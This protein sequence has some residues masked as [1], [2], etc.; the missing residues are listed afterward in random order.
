MQSQLAAR[1]AEARK[2]IRSKY[3]Q[4]E[5]ASPDDPI[6]TILSVEIEREFRFLRNCLTN[7]E[8]VQIQSRLD[9]LQPSV[10]EVGPRVVDPSKPM[11][12]IFSEAQ[13]EYYFLRRLLE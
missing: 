9:E 2:V 3:D 8:V 13:D 6:R 1:L 11:G 7:D 10:V 4:I 5:S 12:N